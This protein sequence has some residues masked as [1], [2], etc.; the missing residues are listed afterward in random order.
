MDA[1]ITANYSQPKVEGSFER[2][3][4]YSK[5]NR[6]HSF[7]LLR[8]TQTF[9]SCLLVKAEKTLQYFRS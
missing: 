5:R 3:N 4:Y 2:G 1:Y 8:E 9:V 6:K 7:S